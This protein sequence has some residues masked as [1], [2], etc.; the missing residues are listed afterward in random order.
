MGCDIHLFTEKRGADGKWRHAPAVMHTCWGCDGKKIYDTHYKPELIGTT[1][2]ACKGKGEQPGEYWEGRNYCLF[3]ILADV[4]NGHG[5]AGIQT[6]TRFEPIAPRRGLPPD[7]CKEAQEYIGDDDGFLHSTSWVALPELLDDVYWKKTNKQ[8]GV[9]PARSEDAHSDEKE[10]TYESFVAGK[11]RQPASWCGDIH[12]PSII[13]LEEREYLRLKMADKLEADKKYHVRVWW[14]VT[15]A[16]AVGHFYTE[17]IPKLIDLA[18]GD[19][20]S[21]RL[22]FAFDN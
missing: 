15:Y 1:C 18:A 9:I 6:G 8:C 5:F 17:T 16:E 7:A 3:A 12:G 2:L 21:V 14:E 11:R 19:P 20:S 10:S 13:V 4:R 22:V